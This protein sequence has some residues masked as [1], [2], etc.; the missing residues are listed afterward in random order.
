MFPLPTLYPSAIQKKKNEGVRLHHGCVC[1]FFFVFSI[2]DYY[3]LRVICFLYTVFRYF[4]ISFIVSVPYIFF[5]VVFA[6]Y[7]FLSNCMSTIIVGMWC[8]L[9]MFQKNCISIFRFSKPDKRSWAVLA[10]DQ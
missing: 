6:F 5:L 4:C 2:I 10:S 7:L 3:H 1:L 9:C 8:M